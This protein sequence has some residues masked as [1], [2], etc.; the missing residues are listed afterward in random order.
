MT[1]GK[2]TSYG[3]EFGPNYYFDILVILQKH[4]EVSESNW[5]R[6]KKKKKTMPDI[7]RWLVQPNSLTLSSVQHYLIL[8]CMPNFGLVTLRL[9]PLTC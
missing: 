5:K 2:E 8:F 4:Q 9:L 3:L 6:T 7:E 1:V